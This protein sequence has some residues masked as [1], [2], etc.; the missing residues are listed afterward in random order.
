MT[1]T[2]RH[3][4]SEE[5]EALARLQEASAVGGFSNVFPPGRPFPR[6]EVLASWRELLEREGRRGARRRRR[7]ELLGFAVPASGVGSSGSTR[8]RT[9]GDEVSARG[10]TTR[11]SSSSAASARRGAVSGCS[12][13]TDGRARSTSA[14]AGGSTARRESSRSAAPARRRLHARLLEWPGEGVRFAP[15][16]TGSLH[17]G[18]ALSAV[19]NRARATGCSC[20]STTPT[21]RGTSRAGGGDPSRPRVARRR[22]GR[23]PVRQSER[24]ERYREAAA[25]L[26]DRFD[27]VTLVREDGRPT[28]H[29]ASVVDDVDFGITH[30]IRGNDH[31]PNE[32]LHRRLTEA[33]GR[34]AARVRPPRADPRRGRQEALEARRGGDRRV[35]SRGRD[36]RRGRARTSRSSASGARRPLRPAADPA[37]R[38]RRDRRALGRRA[39]P[40]GGRSR[41]TRLRSEAPA[42]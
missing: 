12:K 38:D 10:C 32:A 26:G 34:H 31:R 14:A 40:R 11:R 2:L 33:L 9:P 23:G 19:A 4:R 1:F 41:S 3:A 17:V 36:P 28:Y 6:D 39:Q 35:A 25:T 13:R 7:T 30:V 29:L 16:P 21:P 20:G 18:N 24:A 42:T 8:T 37:A 22:V 27:G 15:S 5:A